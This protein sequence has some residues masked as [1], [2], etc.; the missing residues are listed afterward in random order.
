[1]DFVGV[2]LASYHHWG[3]EPSSVCI[4]VKENI[5]SLVEC[6]LLVLTLIFTNR[7]SVKLH[8]RSEKDARLNALNA[9][10]FEL[11]Q[12]SMEHPFV[13][14][15]QFMDD[16][17]TLRTKYKNETIQDEKEKDRCIRY[18]I[19]C[20]MWFNFI[21]DIYLSFNRDEK[22]MLE[23]LNIERWVKDHRLPL[24]ELGLLGVQGESGQHQA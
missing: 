24:R 8:K 19:Y 13:E 5:V 22:E 14:E 9:H 4:W 18:E 21:E 16:W 3:A 2:I 17:T 23:Y 11:H 10:L 6:A 1:M 20:K 12:L 15:K 7:L